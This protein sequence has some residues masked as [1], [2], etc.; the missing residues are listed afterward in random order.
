MQKLQSRQGS[1]NVLSESLLLLV[2]FGVP[3]VNSQ[4]AGVNVSIN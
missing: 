1:K 3:P 4:L 2:C